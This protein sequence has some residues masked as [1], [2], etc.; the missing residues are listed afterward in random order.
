MWAWVFGRT[1][2]GVALGEALGV[3]EGVDEGVG[4]AQYA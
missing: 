2:E 1:W 3:D 4:V